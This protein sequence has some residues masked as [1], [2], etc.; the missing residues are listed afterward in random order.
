MGRFYIIQLSPEPVA[1]E[2]RVKG[3]HLY[4]DPA[5]EARADYGGDPVHDEEEVLGEIAG[6]LK[7]VATVSVKDRTVTFTDPDTLRELYARDIKNAFDEHMRKLRE[8]KKCDWWRFHR[9]IE[10]VF[11]ISDLF[12]TNGYCQK[13]GELVE[14]LINGNIPATLHIGAILWAHC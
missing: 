11:G 4:D 14:D 6:E 2:F 10:D 12:F 8:E 9:R 1:D 7:D 13:A 5:F 3:S